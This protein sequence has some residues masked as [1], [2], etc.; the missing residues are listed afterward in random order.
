[1]EK[2]IIESSVPSATI[3]K[4]PTNR[5]K[6][7]LPEEKPKK[8]KS[9]F[10]V[11]KREL[12]KI[13][14]VA[15]A[16]NDIVPAHRF[17]KNS[18]WIKCTVS[19]NVFDA[20]SNGALTG[21]CTEWL[22]LDWTF[23]RARNISDRTNLTVIVGS[24]D[25]IIGKYDLTPEELETIPHSL[26]FEISGTVKSQVGP[27]GTVKLV[28][29]RREAERPHKAEPSQ[30]KDL[31]QPRL[32]FLQKQI[33]IYVKIMR[34]TITDLNSVHLLEPNSPFV[35]VTCGDD[36][37]SESTSV[38]VKS[39]DRGMWDRLL[40]KLVVNSPAVFVFTVTSIT[41]V[42]GVITLPMIE[43]LGMMEKESEEIE[44]CKSIMDNGF[45]S[46]EIKILLQ[47]DLH[48]PRDTDIFPLSSYDDV[49]QE[50]TEYD[51]EQKDIEKDILIS[52][53]GHMPLPIGHTGFDQNRT[54]IQQH[55]SLPFSMT[56][57]SVA[58]LDTKNMSVLVPNS[59]SVHAA[60]G[61]IAFATN[62]V[63]YN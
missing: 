53:F 30:L 57:H 24:K 10:S 49:M 11:N 61:D 32:L 41:T 21:N 47:L 4:K 39:G 56:V 12:T 2:Q 58:A 63:K 33:P 7:K 15:V 46:G 14:I 18:L 31:V 5:K 51:E 42:I 52:R 40:W 28:C 62:K 6:G 54:P 59:L 8:D 43:I 35:R 26:Y 45:L 36:K 55:I 50:I 22:D 38:L 13:T 20:D 1:M 29:Q 34:I 9:A 23:V 25:V 60:S 3:A 48:S 16:L 44:I 17:A 27:S 19:G 37:W